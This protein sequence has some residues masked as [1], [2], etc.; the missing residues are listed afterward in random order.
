MKATAISE[1]HLYKK[2]YAKGQK[3]FGRHIV[4]YVLT[5]Y[6]ASRLAREN[7]LKTKVN[8][9]GITVTKKLGKAVVR[10]RVRRILRAAYSSLEREN[11][12]KKG[13]LIV[14]AARPAAVTAKSGDIYG[15]MLYAAGKLGLILPAPQK[16]A[17]SGTL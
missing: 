17:E 15:D 4:V 8:R 6:H 7:P 5:D 9:L 12:I 14:I 1:N 3:A 16:P 10:T 13:L 11:N 2:A